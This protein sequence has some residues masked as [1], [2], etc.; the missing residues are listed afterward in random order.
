MQQ[1][2]LIHG[3]NALKDALKYVAPEPPD[4]GLR[5]SSASMRRYI[6]LACMTLSE[7]AVDQNVLRLI[8]A[9]Y[10]QPHIDQHFRFKQYIEEFL[11]ADRKLMIHSGL[12][13]RVVNYL[14]Q[15]AE[16]IIAELNRG[17]QQ[18]PMRLQERL[19]DMRS[20]ACEGRDPKLSN[21]K[22]SSVRLIARALQII[23]GSA[24]VVTNALHMG[25]LG[26]ASGSLSQAL[27]GYVVGK[28]L[29]G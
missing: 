23:G 14:F 28:G 16:S 2:Y 22:S 26:D 7:L 12:E 20:L 18:Q 15:D 4:V 24:V 3:A 1:H 5:Y 29:D 21:T 27:G 25:L 6:E 19:N 10:E 17:E 13:P 9:G 11:R 8:E